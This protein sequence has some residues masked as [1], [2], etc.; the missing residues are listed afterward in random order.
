MTQLVKITAPPPDEVPALV[1]AQTTMSLAGSLEWIEQNTDELLSLL[2]QHGVLLFRNMPI[3]TAV[4]FD[5]F[6]CEFG[7]ENFPYEK[8]L[9]NAVRVNKTDRVFT[10]NEAPSDIEIFLHHEMAQTPIFPTKIFFCC[11]D[12]PDT[13]GQ[14]PICR[15]DLLLKRLTQSNP[16]F[17]RDCET[18]GL[19]YSN[20]MPGADDLASGM[21]RSWQSTLSVESKSDAEDRLKSMNY[22]WEWLDGDSLRVTT[23]VLPA[24]RDL[25]EGRKSFFNQLIAAFRG[26]KDT[27]ND[28]SKSLRHGDDT[29]LDVD[30]VNLA[31]ELAYEV[32]CDL[33]WRK[34]D[35]ALVDNLMVMHG[36]RPF[37]GTR[38]VLASLVL[39]ATH[40]RMA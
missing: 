40:A 15:S 37:T 28:P 11:L 2:G 18:K 22:S 3:R 38:S 29:P 27:R 12:A 14:T 26:W 39:P 32:T 13:G 21:G 16:E 30:A 35:V 31:V 34:G 7:W 20:V 24:V 17:V 19:K 8:S 6:V 9:S 36:R 5:S 25:P 33:A 10:A 23:P 1:E 4:D